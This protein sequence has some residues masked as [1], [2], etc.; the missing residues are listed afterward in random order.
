M[1]ELI[2]YGASD[3]LLEVE[4][5]LREEFEC[6]DGCK[7]YVSDPVTGERL[8]VQAEFSKPGSASDWTLSV[9]NDGPWPDWPIR[10]GQR[11]DMEDDPAIFLEVPVGV[12]LTEVEQ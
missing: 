1:A 6:Y 10:F 12:T 8:L 9:E 7:I 3:D 5:V 4:G 2:I 11:P